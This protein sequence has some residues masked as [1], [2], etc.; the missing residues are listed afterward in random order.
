MRSYYV[1]LDVQ[2]HRALLDDSIHFSHFPIYNR[3]KPCR[4][5]VPIHRPCSSSSFVNVHGLDRAI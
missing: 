1:F 2:V 3:I 5:L 4:L